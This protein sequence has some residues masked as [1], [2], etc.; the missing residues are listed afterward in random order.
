MPPYEV[1]EVA[2]HDAFEL[3]LLVG[4]LLEQAGLPL[5]FLP[6]CNSPTILPLSEFC[7]STQRP[8]RPLRQDRRRRAPVR[9]RCPAALREQG[10]QR[11][12]GYRGLRATAESWQPRQLHPQPLPQLLELL[13]PLLPVLL[14]CPQ[15]A[16]R[17]R[18]RADHRADGA[19]GA[20]GA[21]AR[22]HRAA[23]RRR[24]ASVAA[25]QLLR[26]HAEGVERAQRE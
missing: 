14:L 25:L 19:E 2:R 1:Q 5:F 16:R 17:G 9:R 6:D 23:H 20:R 4:P 3:H 22:H 13:H 11:R 24:A 21:G 18:L 7:H 15:E 10:H 26:G 8:A 12:R